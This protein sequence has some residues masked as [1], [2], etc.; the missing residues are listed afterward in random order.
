MDDASREEDWKRNVVASK[1]ERQKF[2]DVRCEGNEQMT[3][4]AAASCSPWRH[5][6]NTDAQIDAADVMIV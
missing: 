6:L 5:L 1:R 2:L 3:L 4:M